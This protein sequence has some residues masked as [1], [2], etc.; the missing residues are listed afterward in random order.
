MLSQFICRTVDFRCGQFLK[1]TF[2]LWRKF[3]NILMGLLLLLS[4]CTINDTDNDSIC[5]PRA[6]KIYLK[7]CEAA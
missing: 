7:S 2:G 6:E 3:I 1:H 5:L 4:I